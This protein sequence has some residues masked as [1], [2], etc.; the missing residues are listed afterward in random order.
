MSD[1]D[2][3][4]NPLGFQVISYRLDKDLTNPD[5]TPLTLGTLNTTNQA[6]AK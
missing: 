1:E 4:I 6:E 3:L 5:I 2:R